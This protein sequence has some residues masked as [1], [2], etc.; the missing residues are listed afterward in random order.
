MH[1][2]EIVRLIFLFEGIAMLITGPILCFCPAT[3]L[4]LY[5]APQ[6]QQ[7]GVDAPGIAA[8]IVPWFGALVSL[9]GWTESRTG[10]R[11]TR[12]EVEGWLVGDLLYIYGFYL[13]VQRYSLWNFWTVGSIAFPVLYAPIRVYWLLFCGDYDVKHEKQR[14]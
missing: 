14:S 4:S 11:L 10:G 8:D 6:Y 5:T 9:M 3:V 1:A 2:K 12:A 7:M 13:W